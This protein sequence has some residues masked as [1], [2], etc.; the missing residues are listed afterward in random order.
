MALDPSRLKYNAFD[1]ILVFAED[2]I[3]TMRDLFNINSSVSVRLWVKY[4]SNTFEQLGKL[5][6]T[7]QDAGLFTGQLIVI[8]KQNEDGSWPRE[9]AKE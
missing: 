1:L 4:T 2:V 8:E 7:V 5:D 9:T 6:Q 3:T